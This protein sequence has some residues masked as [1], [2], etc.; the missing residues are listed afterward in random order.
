MSTSD[1]LSI[2]VKVKK[3]IELIDRY[4]VGVVGILILFATALWFFGLDEP[5]EQKIPK[6]FFFSLQFI[7]LNKSV[8]DECIDDQKIR[9]LLYLSQFA[10]PLFASS[11]LIANLFN[12]RIHPFLKRK[13]VNSYQGHH[14]IVS[15][16]AFGKAL[17]EALK[18]K[19]V[20]NKIVAIEKQ[21][22][23]ELDD[24]SNLTIIYYDAMQIDLATEAN[25]NVAS[26]LYLMLPDE[27]DNL[28]LLK[29]IK[30]NT[31]SNTKL[32]V[33]LRTQSF[34]MHH[35]LMDWVSI[36]AFKH[37]GLDVHVSNPYAVAARGIVNR[38]SPDLY[39]PTDRT[40]PVSQVVMIIG[41]SEMA[42]AL[43]LRFARIGIYS[44]KGKL[45]LIWVGEGVTNALNELK[46]LYP[47][48][49]ARYGDLK[50][51]SSIQNVSREYFDSVLPPVMIVPKDQTTEQAICNGT[52]AG[53]DRVSWPSAIYVCHDSDIR[54]LAEARTIQSSL[55]VKPEAVGLE[56]WGKNGRLIL[57]IQNESELE[58]DHNQALLAFPYGIKE[59]CIDALFAKTV[60]D[61]RADELAKEYHAVY[62]NFHKKKDIDD[63][64]FRMSM[65]W[66]ESNRDLSDHLAIKA[67]YAGINPETVRKLVFDGIDSISSTDE[68]RMMAAFNDLIL[69]EERRYRAFMFMNDFRYGA[70]ASEYRDRVVTT[71]ALNILEK[72][73]DQCLRVNKTLLEEEL[74]DVERQKDDNIVRKSILLLKKRHDGLPMQ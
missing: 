8:D 5:W 42:K 60:V 9:F 44:P 62:S 54:N 22:T 70:H 24:Q 32:N 63:E 57:A 21:S 68:A 46:S 39:V 15:Y 58:I 65:L 45:R 40:G 1:K 12:E 25:L 26:T 49:D 11:T 34:A 48:L 41:V 47:A 53:T 30:N 3:V 17:E 52:I 14:I 16:G 51:W 38:Y 18:K 37:D 55:C 64:W 71:L 56:T 7:V 59:Q 10:I 27:R 13:T 19:N 28:S 67:R 72:E 31:A 33:Y 35:L 74:P 73:I 61:D 50:Q 69:M 43:V 29:K 66:K 2:W 36:T 23:S 20:N 6:A 4:G